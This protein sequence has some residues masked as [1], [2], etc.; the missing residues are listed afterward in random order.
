MINISSRLQVLFID[1]VVFVYLDSVD[2]VEV[3][4]PGA[5]EDHWSCSVAGTCKHETIIHVASVSVHIANARV[6]NHFSTML[7]VLNALPVHLLRQVYFLVFWK[8]F[9]RV[10]FLFIFLE[11]LEAPLGTIGSILELFRWH[12]GVILV[13]FL[14]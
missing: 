12:S 3:A 9:F 10:R 5:A 6:V 11:G 7:W 13:A 4:P 2:V 1:L 8:S 14:G